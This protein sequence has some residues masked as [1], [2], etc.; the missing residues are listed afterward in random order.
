MNRPASVRLF[1]ASLLPHSAR[2][3]AVSSHRLH[4]TTAKLQFHAST[5]RLKKKALLASELLPD[6]EEDEKKKKKPLQNPR[7]EAIKHTV[8]R[9]VNP[10]TGALEPPAR[11]RDVLP[12]V[13]RKKQYL[14]LVVEK[15]EPIVKI[16]NL[17]ERY[18]RQRAKH[19]QQVLGRAPEE[20]ELQVTWG[21]GAG[22]LA[23]KLRKARE[24]LTAGDRVTLVFAPKKGQKTPET[25]E[26]KNKF[27]E[28]AL[29]LLEDVGRERKDRT[30][31]NHVVALYLEPLRPKQIIDLN[32][33]HSGHESWTGL[34]AVYAGL[35]SGARV[36]VV[37]NLPP[38]PK[39]ARS[40]PEL[41]AE[42]VEPEVVKESVER[43]VQ[44]LIDVAREWQP[45]ENRKS[46]VI[47]H[48]EDV[49]AIQDVVV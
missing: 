7:N 4:S 38:P 31:Q 8:V 36:D 34:S 3:A 30:A 1:D 20:K 15:P 46:S 12:R 2:V 16:I 47:L 23:F 11:L 48:L 32:W 13:D 41:A 39:A 9:L 45:R 28:E 29:R 19:I 26:E 14:E 27:V 21:V 49:Q 35:R 42:V 10:Q 44:R 24:D 18:D 6:N 40:D 43:T 37:F 33:A 5:S 17:K 22:D 25:P